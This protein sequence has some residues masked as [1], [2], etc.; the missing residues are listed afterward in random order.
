MSTEK[1]EV[2]IIRFNKTSEDVIAFAYEDTNTVELRYPK[3]FYSSMLDTDTGEEDMTIIDWMSPAT[4]G[5]QE[6]TINKSD[7]LF[8]S[9][10]NV[11]FGHYYLSVLVDELDPESKLSKQLTKVLEEFNPT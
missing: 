10:P 2:R 7:I 4:F 11:D 9:Y 5:E 1:F 8:I 6:V 3:L